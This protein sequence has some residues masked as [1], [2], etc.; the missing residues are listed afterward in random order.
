MERCIRWRASSSSHAPRFHQHAAY[1]GANDGKPDFANQH[2]YHLCWAA[3]ACLGKPYYARFHS[4]SNAHGHACDVARCIY[5][6]LC[7]RTWTEAIQRSKCGPYSIP[8]IP[9]NIQTPGLKDCRRGYGAWHKDRSAAAEDITV[10]G[11]TPRGSLITPDNPDCPIT[12]DPQA[13][14]VS[15]DRLR[16]SYLR[17]GVIQGVP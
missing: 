12:P 2:T 3:V 10:I 17:H 11:K 14:Q 15:S 13:G 8:P 4:S 5:E 16:S 9:S 1:L 6:C 7:L